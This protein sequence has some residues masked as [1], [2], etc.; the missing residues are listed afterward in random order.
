MN[1]DERQS[2]EAVYSSLAL[3]FVLG[4]SVS[5]F[6]C[7][8]VPIPNPFP[9][10]T[11]TTIPANGFSYDSLIWEGKFRGSGAKETVAAKNLNVNNQNISMEWTAHTWSCGDEFCDGVIMVA[12]QSDG[13]WY[14]AYLDYCQKGA[15]ATSGIACRT[16]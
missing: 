14:S 1:H 4:M 13:Y 15:P 9:V 8:T 5:L 10:T 11:T 6:S 3:I 12:W 7:K 16:W 2:L